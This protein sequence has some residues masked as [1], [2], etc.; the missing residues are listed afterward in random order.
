VQGRRRH[1]AL[2]VRAG[3][4]LAAQGDDPRGGAGR[5]LQPRVLADIHIYLLGA[6]SEPSK[7]E[8]QA[9]CSTRLSILSA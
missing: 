7:L 2:Q 3:P 8:V 4:S 5:G 1:P 9:L 6:F